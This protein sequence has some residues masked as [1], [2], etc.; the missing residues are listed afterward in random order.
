MFCNETTKVKIGATAAVVKPLLCRSWKCPDCAPRRATALRHKAKAG[1]PN[2]FL[3]LTVS[4]T[5]YETPELAANALVAAWRLIRRRAISEARRDPRKRLTPFGAYSPA[6]NQDGRFGDATRRVEL[7][8]GKLPFMAFFER[9]EAGWPHLHILCT[10]N[11]I[12]QAW[13]SAQTAELLNSPIVDVRRIRTVRGVASYVTKYVT[14]S[15]V[16]FDTLKRYYSSRKYD[17]RPKPEKLIEPFPEIQWVTAVN[18]YTN[19]IAW[20]VTKFRIEPK[21]LGPWYIFDPDG[22][23]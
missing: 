23:D 10:A 11:W 22:G 13:L 19:V 5:Q 4:A 14:K 20:L 2:I 9:T 12:D 18:G 21:R 1:K 17:P 16:K 8:N 15:L 3:T 6:R 7:L